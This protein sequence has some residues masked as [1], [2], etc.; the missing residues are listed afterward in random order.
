[1]FGLLLAA[2]SAVASPTTVAAANLADTRCIAMLALQMEAADE[3]SKPSLVA[4][5]LYYLGR[6]DARAPNYD[7]ETALLAL[8]SSEQAKAS[9]ADDAQRCGSLIQERGA[10]IATIGKSLE[11]SQADQ[12]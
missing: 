8:M 5:F 12:R 6:L 4:A 3:S 2:A 9:L 7:I 10:A 1:M 11:E